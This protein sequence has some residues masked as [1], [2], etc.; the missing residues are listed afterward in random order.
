MTDAYV[1]VYL[2]AG[3]VSRAA[4]EIGDLDAVSAVHLVTGE[5]DVVVQLDVEDR[6]RIPDVV[7]DDILPVSGVV[8]TVT[9]VAYE[10]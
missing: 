9:N 3:A 10:P 7:V 4:E 5:Y 1:N 6:N 8:D 2:E